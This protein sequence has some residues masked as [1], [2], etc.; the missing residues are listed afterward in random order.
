MK[1]LMS[2]PGS[3]NF[4]RKTAR[5]AVYCILTVA[6]I[7][8]AIPSYIKEVK[9]GFISIHVLQADAFLHGRLS[10]GNAD[11]LG[12]YELS[13][14]EGKK[15]VCLP[16]FPSILL[17]PVVAIWGMNT[18]F[19]YLGL[20]LAL[21]SILILKRILEQLQIDK[22]RIPWLICAFVVGSAY[23][24]CIRRS[25]SPWLTAHIVAVTC[26]LLAI[27][28]ALGKGRGFIVGMFLGMAI[29]SRQLS[30]YSTIF[31]CCALWHGGVNGTAAPNRKRILNVALF[32]TGTGIWIS[33]YL[34]FNWARFGNPFDTGYAYIP[35]GGFLKER[36]DQYGM[37][38]QGFHVVFGG[39]DML[40]MKRLDSMGTSITFASPFIFY[41]FRARW[42][43]ILRIGAWATITF[44]LL[45]MMLYYNNGWNQFNCQRFTM[46]F[47]PVLMLLVALGID[48]SESNIW[49]YVISYSVILNILAH[50]VFPGIMC[51]IESLS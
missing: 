14:F 1:Q 6:V 19:T 28:E 44:C 31:L 23:W 18:H 42:P 40:T 12:A 16:P 32:L 38:L 41:A 39:A 43:K 36:V 21:F 17:M 46:D 2:P 10:V 20:A 45:H 7:V 22:E 27:H 51:F 34:A 11:E 8:T 24:W 25:G 33:I 47:M 5:I 35:L 37:F 15:Y 13:V 30:V 4:G 3:S 50:L 29:L 48:R 9:P 26:V 49:K